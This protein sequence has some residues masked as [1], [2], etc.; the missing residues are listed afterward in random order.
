MSNKETGVSPVIG[1]LLMLTLTLI[2]A[3]VCEYVT[4]V[5]LVKT[6]PKPPSVTLQVSYSTND[7]SGMVIRHMSGDPIPSIFISIYDTSR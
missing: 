6:D 1:V 4:P 5:D 3:A 2:I 7:P